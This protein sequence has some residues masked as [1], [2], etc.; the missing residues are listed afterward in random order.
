MSEPDEDAAFD[1]GDEPY[2]TVQ[3]IGGVAYPVTVTTDEHGQ[4]EV[5]AQPATLGYTEAG[6]DEDPIGPPLVVESAEWTAEGLMAQ[7][8]LYAGHPAYAAVHAGLTDSLSIG[9]DGVA[10]VSDI[11][12]YVNSVDTRSP[13]H[14]TFQAVPVASPPVTSGLG[15]EHIQRERLRRVPPPAS[16]T[17]PAALGGL[18]EDAKEQPLIRYNRADLR[19]M[20]RKGRRR[21]H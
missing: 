5:L 18:P 9:P 4:I 7:V 2:E 19:A 10:A 17:L 13:V 12:P 11:G 14:A 20:R 6:L 1:Q 15:R 21:G 3:V 8:H 16:V